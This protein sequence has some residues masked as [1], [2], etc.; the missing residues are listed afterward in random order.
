M[1]LFWL[2]AN[3]TR[4][5]C[6]MDRPRCFECMS[7]AMLATCRRSTIPYCN[8]GRA[9]PSPRRLPQPERGHG[10]GD[11]GDHYRGDGDPS[12]C[13]SASERRS[14]KMA[15]STCSRRL[16]LATATLNGDH[17]AS[18]T[19]SYRSPALLVTYRTRPLLMVH[20]KFSPSLPMR[21]MPRPNNSVLRWL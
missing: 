1:I 3:A 11:D 2:P 12:D 10:D 13:S 6:R 8:H 4:Q 14:W 19:G 18:C 9:C 20:H 17:E 21:C 7:L 15:L 5:S 16:Y